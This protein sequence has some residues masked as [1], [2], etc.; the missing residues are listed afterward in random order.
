MYEE[1]IVLLSGGLDSTTCLAWAVRNYASVRTITFAYGQKHRI[2]LAAAA[3]VSAEFEVDNIVMR[4]PAECFQE[5]ALTDRNGA[6]P[7]TAGS[8]NPDGLPKTF[9]PA[10]NLVFL[11]LSAGMAYR[12]G[13]GAA[14]LVIG[15]NDVDYSGYPDCRPESILAAQIAVRNSLGAPDMAI[16]APL[17]GLSK[18]EI[19]LLLIDLYPSRWEELLAMTVSC[20]NGDK[21]GCG[22]CDSCRIRANAFRLLHI[23]DPAKGK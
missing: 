11:S 23:D 1:A 16:Q 12:K 5:T 21:S 22:E 4:L 10:R 2:E 6:E 15:A 20:Y 18:P 9:V 3:R 17:L 8:M 13:G 14:D 19:I 7:V